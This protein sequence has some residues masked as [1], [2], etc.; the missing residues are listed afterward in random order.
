M[1]AKLIKHIK[2]KTLFIALKKK[3]YTFIHFRLNILSDEKYLI[4][5]GKVN[6][7]YKMDI[8]NP[9]TFNEK[10][11]YYKIHYYNELMPNA[12]DKIKAKQYVI[13]KGLEKIVIKTLAT[14]DSL[15]EIYFEELP[16]SFV[17]KNTIDSGGVFKCDDKSK[18]I[19]KDI[20]YKKLKCYLKSEFVN[21][22]HVS[23]ENVYAKNKNRIIVEELLPTKDGH[24]PLDY[25]IFCFYG[26]P[27]FLFVASNR[28]T[29]CCF[30]FFDINFN[31]I[32]VKQGHP[33]AS[34]RPIKPKNFDKM[35]EYARILS[36]DFPHVRVDLY[37]LDG[38]IYFGELTFYH[39]SGLT[40]FQPSDY[41]LKFGEYFDIEKLK[42]FKN[43]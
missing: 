8:N 23:L 28:D 10:L 1:K 7:K 22:K 43:E 38:K 42:D 15:D 34:I 21:G 27:K 39:F 25:K 19:D 33:N 26:E 37:N 41:D 18:I 40:P 13:D 6:L 5:L 36:K 32:N 4:K 2:N 31:W 3:F 16:N 20:I 29:N 30:D 24:A 17:I 9:K 35:L 12:V 11:N 14:Y